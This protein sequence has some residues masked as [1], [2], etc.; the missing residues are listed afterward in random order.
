[1]TN[2]ELTAH[3]L[4]YCKSDLTKTALMLTGPW[5]CG[6]SY[7][8]KNELIPALED[9]E[10]YRDDEAANAGNI[11]PKDLVIRCA[12]VS[13]YGIASLDDISKT[14]YLELRGHKYTSETDAALRI[15]L[16]TVAKALIGYKGF[17]FSVSAEDQKALFLSADLGQ[18]LLIFEDFERCPLDKIEVLGYINNLVEQDGVRVLIVANEGELFSDDDTNDNEEI[19][20]TETRI[21]TA[22]EYA[23]RKEKTVGDTLVFSPNRKEIIQ[24]IFK[25]FEF[26]KLSLLFEDESILS[27]LDEFTNFYGNNNWRSLVY[28]CQKTTEI[29]DLMEGSEALDD[30]DFL[31]CIFLSTVIYAM[32]TKGGEEVKIERIDFYHK[33]GHYDKYPLFPFCHNYLREHRFQ[34]SEM[35][36]AQEIYRKIHLYDRN[37]SGGDPDIQTLRCYHITTEQQLTEALASLKRKLKETP[38]EIS[39]YEYADIGKY[40]ILL[41]QIFGFDLTEQK[42]LLVSNLRGHWNDINTVS[43]DHVLYYSEGSETGEALKTLVK[44]MKDSL[45]ETDRAIFDFDYQPEHIASFSDTVIQNHG[46]ILDDRS[47]AKRLDIE[48]TVAMLRKCTAMQLDEFR[49]MFNRVYEFANIKDFFEDDRDILQ[50]LYAA[51]RE[52]QT[53]TDYDKIQKLQ[54]QWLETLLAQTLEKLADPPD[55]AEVP[56]WGRV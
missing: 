4:R 42:E 49:L 29:F 40:L 26:T 52:E 54:L 3:I 11:D 56:A 46:Q 38:E 22:K 32:K 16:K 55:E 14:L 15:G 44:R 51:V 18:T 13:L 12:V 9:P 37:R 53:S 27:E 28:A 19:E 8:I 2:K 21:K 1:M 50:D 6:K 30:K 45:Q 20:A 48:K 34:I 47:F 36:N 7:Y 35:Q 25:E 43:F 39:F 5:G 23:R 33:G 24:N 17:D 41:E 31:K 10:T